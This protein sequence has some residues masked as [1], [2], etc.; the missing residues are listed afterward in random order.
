MIKAGTITADEFV[1]GYSDLYAI[2][3]GENQKFAS[4]SHADSLKAERGHDVGTFLGVVTDIH[5]H[6]KFELYQANCGVEHCNCA[7]TAKEVV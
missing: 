3:D 7:L 6:K 1:K 5:T 4:V 2:I